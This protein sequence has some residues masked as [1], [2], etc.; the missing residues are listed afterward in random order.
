VYFIGIQQ[1]HNGLGFTFLRPKRATT[2]ENDAQLTQLGTSALACCLPCLLFI[3]LAG[4]GTLH[5][6]VTAAPHSFFSSVGC[7]L[8]RA[9]RLTTEFSH[10]LATG[11]AHSVLTIHLV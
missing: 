1:P 5:K 8:K 10:N 3:G 2:V 9:I 7:A 11:W 4:G 6:R